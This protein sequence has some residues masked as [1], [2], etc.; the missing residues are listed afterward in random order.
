MA[1][2]DEMGRKPLIEIPPPAA[3]PPGVVLFLCV[4]FLHSR[5]KIPAYIVLAKAARAAPMRQAFS[6]LTMA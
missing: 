1:E 4:G 5:L 2:K 3:P 6:A